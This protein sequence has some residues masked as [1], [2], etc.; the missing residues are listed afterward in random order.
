MPFLDNFDSTII[1]FLNKLVGKSRVLDESVEL[2]EKSFLLSGVL[3]LSLLWYR[4]FKDA[5]AKSRIRLLFGAVTAVLAGVLSRVLQHVLPFHV[6]PLYNPHLQLRFPIGI[7]P[8]PLSQWNSFPSD[9]AC[10]YFALATVICLSDRRLGIFAFLCAAITSCARIYL[11]VHY[12]SDVLGGAILGILAV[13]LFKMLPLPRLMDRVLDWERY[14][15]PSFYAFAFIA[16]YLI[17]TLFTDLRALAH[18]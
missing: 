15:S 18:L 5:R 12:P 9:H 16:S 1:L 13:T 10:I 4:W 3:L 17:A 2:I 11:G 6:R 14:A 7:A 8:G